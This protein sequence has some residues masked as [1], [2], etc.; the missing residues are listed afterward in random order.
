MKKRVNLTLLILS[1]FFIYSGAQNLIV[2]RPPNVPTKSSSRG[3]NAKSSSS[4]GTST[5]TIN[6][7]N[8]KWASNITYAQKEVITDIL[9][10]M[11]YIP[12]N[13]YWMGND[14]ET[15]Y[16]DEQP[17]HYVEINAFRISKYEVT[18]YEWYTI[19]GYNPST[20]K[21]DNLPVTDISYHECE[22]FI[23]KLKKLSGVSFKIPNETQWE[24]AAK[25]GQYFNGYNHF[26][27]S[28]NSYN[29]GW[30][31]ENSGG[32][33]HPVGMKS[34]NELGLYD[35]TGNVWEWTCSGWCDGY[36][37]KRDY[38][39]NVIRGGSYELDARKARNTNRRHTTRDKKF[40]SL[41]L[42]LVIQ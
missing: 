30:T 15:S 12:Y 40:K 6:G 41:G 31:E 2:R 1:A 32:Y 35:M 20:Y 16:P 11:V 37:A 3:S 26:S 8:V 13:H 18:Q 9:R 27:G 28:D 33:P 25:G 19:M 14:D 42:R 36:N 10:S 17:E 23:K 29:V 7:I 21:G 5:T 39:C 38:S 34:S 22:D 4:K 24:Y